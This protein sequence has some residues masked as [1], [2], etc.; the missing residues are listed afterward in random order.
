LLGIITLGASIFSLLI[1]K[2]HSYTKISLPKATS[3]ASI[4]LIE[5]KKIYTLY[6]LE[7]ISKAVALTRR[8][9]GIKELG[10]AGVGGL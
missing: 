10:G 6:C 8:I 2:L 5:T 9:G 7:S 3:S 4:F 1:I